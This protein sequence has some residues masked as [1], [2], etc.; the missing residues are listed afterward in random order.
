M[1]KEGDIKKGDIFYCVTTFRML[2]SS[3]IYV[4]KMKCTDISVYENGRVHLDSVVKTAEGEGH[5][6]AAGHICYKDLDSIKEHLGKVIELRK[7][8]LEG[9]I[10][11]LQEQLYQLDTYKIIIREDKS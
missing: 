3:K 9:Q 11:E 2:T 6:G 10:A 4:D 7:K 5:R 1:I 8:K